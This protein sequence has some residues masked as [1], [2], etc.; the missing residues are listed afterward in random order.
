[1]IQ[2]SEPLDPVTLACPGVTELP[3]LMLRITCLP[4][5]Q[6]QTGK[7]AFTVVPV[8]PMI[9]RSR[10]HGDTMRFPGGTKS[11]KKWFMDEKIPAPRRCR[12]PVIADDLGVLG[13][14]GGGANLDR[15][16][17]DDLVL[18]H[19]ETIENNA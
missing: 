5:S 3:Q 13:V 9:L 11:I 6:S 14:Y 12:I 17:G 1:M 8:G 19:F 10:N 7:T 2:R 18:I 15:T 16:A 4:A